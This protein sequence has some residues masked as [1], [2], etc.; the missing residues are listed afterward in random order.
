MAIAYKDLAYVV[1]ALVVALVCP[2]AALAAGLTDGSA[3]SDA[4][5]LIF[6][7][8]ISS[9]MQSALKVVVC[10]CCCWLSG[11]WF[12]TGL[13]VAQQQQQQVAQNQAAAPLAAPDAR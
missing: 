7:Q 8:S 4:A 1:V 6:A 5:S 10:N 11:C 2:A 3:T 9:R 12:S 13:T